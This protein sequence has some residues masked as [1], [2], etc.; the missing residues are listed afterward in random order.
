MSII[1]DLNYHNDPRVRAMGSDDFKVLSE[2]GS[3]MKI[4]LDESI[5]EMLIEDEKSPEDFDGVLEVEFVYEVCPL[6]QGRG[7]HVNPSI[8]CCGI[9]GED[10]AD[11]PDFAEEY[12]AGTYDQTCN[13][14]S[15]QR[16]VP[17]VKMPPEV[18]A[19]LKSWHASLAESHRAEMAEMRMGA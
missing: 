19:V 12:M 7:K 4:Q 14:C 2:R 9:T 18:A 6:C 15:G 17:V 1:E 11:D 16:V 3:M 13:Q 5:V 8:D 10:F